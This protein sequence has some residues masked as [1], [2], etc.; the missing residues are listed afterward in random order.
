MDVLALFD[1]EKKI[2]VMTSAYTVQPG[3]KGQRINISAQKNN[4]FSLKSYKIVI[5]KFQI[6][7]KLGCSC[8][9]QETFLLANICIKMVLGIF[10]LILSNID[11]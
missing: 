4:R 3:L 6:L 9:F 1:I 10:F 11:V 5:A 7:D 8:F 2:N